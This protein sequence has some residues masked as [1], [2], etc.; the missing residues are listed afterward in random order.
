MATLTYVLRIIAALTLLNIAVKV[1][2]I[3]LTQGMARCVLE[4]PAL[5][6]DAFFDVFLLPI[7]VALNLVTSV[8]SALFQILLSFIDVVI[9]ILWNLVPG[10]SLIPQP[11]IKDLI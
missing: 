6:A 11:K 7:E 8:F 1:V 2:R 5:I 4:L 10:V 3:C 9:G